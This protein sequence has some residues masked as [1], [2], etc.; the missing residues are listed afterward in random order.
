MLPEYAKLYEQNSDI[1]GWISIDDTQIP[2]KATP[3]IV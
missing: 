1:V 2:L 3:V